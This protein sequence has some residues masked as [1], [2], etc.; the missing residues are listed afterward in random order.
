M[1]RGEAAPRVS[2]RD[3]LQNL[4]A[5]IGAALRAGQ[6]VTEFAG[7]RGAGVIFGLPGVIDQAGQR[8]VLV[9]GRAPQSG[10]EPVLLR[11]M[12]LDPDQFT[13]TQRAA[14]A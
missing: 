10:A 14:T 1:I 9:L 4:L 3:G 8:N 2:A 12:Y 13:R 7:E 11:L 6:S 5:A